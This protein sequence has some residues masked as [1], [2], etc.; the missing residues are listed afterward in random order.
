MSST[1]VR[2]SYDDQIRK[3]ISL[4]QSD[5][6][7]FAGLSTHWCQKKTSSNRRLQRGHT[8]DD[9]RIKQ[10]ITIAIYSSRW[11]RLKLQQIIDRI[12]TAYPRT[13]GPTGTRG[14][15]W[16]VNFYS[17]QSNDPGIDRWRFTQET[18]RNKLS[19]YGMFVRCE[20]LPGQKEDEQ[21]VGNHGGYWG[22]DPY[23]ESTS[24]SRREA[25]KAAAVARRHGEEPL[26]IVPK[27]KLKSTMEK[28]GMK[29]RRSVPKRVLSS[30]RAVALP[31]SPIC[32]EAY[33]S[34]PVS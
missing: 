12:M 22:L 29:K 20:A 1:I 34:S 21:P 5:E 19:Y 31:L 24:K 15:K 3:M 23:D 7:S 16:K 17:L 8:G 30:S 11:E 33:H 14:V 28:V 13:Y 6:L 2:L 26:V 25:A 10:L 4:G 27:Q 9:Y 18:I 32:G